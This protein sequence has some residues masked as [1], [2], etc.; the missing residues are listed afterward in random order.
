MRG[1]NYIYIQEIHFQLLFDLGTMA[2]WEN[3]VPPSKESGWPGVERKKK[4]IFRGKAYM[5]LFMER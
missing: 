2:A 4:V 1:G 5:Y 3:G